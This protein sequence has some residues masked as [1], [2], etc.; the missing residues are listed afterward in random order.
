MRSDRGG[1]FRFMSAIPDAKLGLVRRLV[2]TAPDSAVR[3]LVAALAGATDGGLSIVRDLVRDEAA[4]RALRAAVLM[5]VLG[6]GRTVTME[7]ARFD[8]ARLGRVW[9]AVRRR[10]PELSARVRDSYDALRPG[11][12]APLVFDELCL[13]AAAAV[14]DEPEFA[15]SLDQDAAHC[16]EAAPLVRRALGKASAWIG[17]PDPSEAAALR[18]ILKDAAAL[19]EDG[20]PRM[21]N[22]LATHL[23][24]PSLVLRFI[25][26]AL[27]RPA[28]NYLASSE[29][30]GFGEALL[31]E[32]AAGIDRVRA[33][34]P[35]LG[36]DAAKA[37]GQE[38]QTACERIQEFE[39]SLELGRDGPWGK[40]VADLRRTLAA[41]VEARL[42]DVEDAVSVALP[43]Q[44]VRVAGRM[45][46]SAPKLDGA[47]DALRVERARTL[48]LF[49]DGVRAAG[50]AGGF[51]SLRAKTAA[52]VAERLIGYAD[53]ALASVNAGEAPDEALALDHVELAA[54]FLVLADDQR[55]AQ[56]VRRRAGVAGSPGPSRETA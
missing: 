18:L 55:A 56:T 21:L 19:A 41:A 31:T 2:E 4:Q 50:V 44:T 49:L 29:L 3:S 40:R 15:A 54:E 8:A 33:F 47:L 16:L 10:D 53:E 38:V 17:R 23:D 32:I 20:V 46:R 24:E 42:R 52:K 27:E 34:N 6:A 9:A 30:A 51:G 11:D 35:A 25:S 39:T 1:A 22:L 45:T 12:P 26:A 14:R 36:P 48:L 28:D 7:V 5:P 43:T 13:A 37:A